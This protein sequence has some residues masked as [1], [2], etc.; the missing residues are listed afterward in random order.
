LRGFGGSL[1]ADF[2]SECLK[3]L[4]VTRSLR[5]HIL[6]VDIITSKFVYEARFFKI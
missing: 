2:Q 4:D 5:L 1:N 6:A 3:P